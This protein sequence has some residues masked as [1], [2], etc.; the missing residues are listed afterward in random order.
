MPLQA[1]RRSLDLL[2]QSFDPPPCLEAKLTFEGKAE[3]GFDSLSHFSQSVC[4]FSA[5]LVF[6]V[7][8][9]A[10]EPIHGSGINPVRWQALAQ[11]RERLSGTSYKNPHGVVCLD[12]V[13]TGQVRPQALTTFSS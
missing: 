11:E 13:F 9:L 7:V 3:F 1:F 10:D 6:F 8:Q 5:N 4:G 12:C 2:Q